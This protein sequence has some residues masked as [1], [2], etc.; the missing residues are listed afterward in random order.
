[1]VK[2]KVFAKEE[3]RLEANPED[4]LH[5]KVRRSSPDEPLRHLAT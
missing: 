1:L 5:N 4:Q 3:A 2:E